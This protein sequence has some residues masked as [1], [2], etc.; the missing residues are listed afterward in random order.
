M[1]FRQDAFAKLW[2]VEDQGNYCTGSIT[3]SKKDDKAE[4]G[5]TITFRDGYVRFIGEAYKKA[6]DL[7]DKLEHGLTIKI[8]ACD[9][10]TF[11]SVKQKKN[12]VNY[13]IFDFEEVVWDGKKSSGKKKADAKKEKAEADPE[14]EKLAELVGEEELPF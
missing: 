12:Y 3:V 7:Q 8:L 5:Y 6:M 13:A 2:S 14:E 4:N 11:Y 9:V 10:T 1:G